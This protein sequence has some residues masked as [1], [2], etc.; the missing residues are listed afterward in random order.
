MDNFTFFNPVRIHFG[1]G[2][3]SKISRE[4]TRDQKVLITYGGGSIKKN[5][6][7]DQVKAALK[8]ISFIEFGGIEANPHYE[9]LIKAV[10]IVKKEKIDFLLA[11]GGGSVIDGTKFI[12]AAAKYSG[13]PWDIIK[14]SGSVVK[15]ALPLGCVLTIAAT[16]SEM[17]SGASLIHAA[18]NHKVVLH[19]REF[20]PRFSILDPEATFSLPVNQTGNGVVDAFV[21][22]TE[23][24]ITYPVNAKVQDRLSEGLLKTLIEEGP[25]ALENPENYDARANIMWSASMALNGLIKF[26]SPNDW[27][28]HMIGLELTALYGLA[29]GETVA[30]MAPAVWKYKKEE[31]LEKLAMFASNVWDIRS[32]SDEEKADLAI[33][34][35]AEFFE[36]M[37]LKTRLSDYNLDK[38]II[39]EVAAQLKEHGVIALGEHGNITP[40]DAA[41]ILELAL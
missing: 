25:K 20:F 23:Q 2:E 39:P 9:T 33:E 16:G 24:Y 13:D 4:I 10:D 14:S 27:A 18:T 29:H 26:G 21:H 3:I 40:G 31:K 36:K 19:S 12:A 7:L 28:A 15:E 8:G 35:S 17:N 41:K 11:I 37:G 5:G 32:G 34:K 22:V 38:N 30:V 1:K 6:I